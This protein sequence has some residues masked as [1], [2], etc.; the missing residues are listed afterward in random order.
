[1]AEPIVPPSNTLMIT[2]TTVM[3]L[4]INPRYQAQGRSLKAP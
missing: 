2:P 4:E 3:P 1:M